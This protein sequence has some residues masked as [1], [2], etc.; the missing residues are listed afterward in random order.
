MKKIIGLGLALFVIFLGVSGRAATVDSEESPPG[1]RLRE[2]F[3]IPAFDPKLKKENSAQLIKG[4]GKFSSQP[5][6][7][8][9]TN[10]RSQLGAIWSKPEF[11]L[12]LSHDLETS[13]WINFGDRGQDAGDGMALVLHNDPR[14]VAA[15]ASDGQSLG[16]WGQDQGD[17]KPNRIA[18]S[19]IRNSWAL[20]FDT[21]SNQDKSYAHAFDLGEPAGQHIAAN[22]PDDTHTYVDRGTNGFFFGLFGNH[23]YGMVHQNPINDIKLSDG[24]WHHLSLKWRAPVGKPRIGQLTY[25]IDDKDPDTGMPTTIARSQ[26]ADV[27]LNKLN[28]TD[29]RVYWGFT[30]ATGANY[31]DAKVIFES[32]PHIMDIKAEMSVRD[33]QT[34]KPIID[35]DKVIDGRKIQYQYKLNYT[36]GTQPWTNIWMNLPLDPHFKLDIGNIKFMGGHT[37]DTIT[38]KDIKAGHL[39]LRLEQPL[40]TQQNVIQISLVGHAENDDVKSYHMPVVNQIFN[41]DNYIAEMI[42]PAYQVM[43]RRALNLSLGNPATD[44]LSL[45]L[46]RQADAEI[47]GTIA[48]RDNA[49][50]AWDSTQFDTVSAIL[51][52]KKLTNQQYKLTWVNPQTGQFKLTVPNQNLKVGQNKLTLTVTDKDGTTTNQVQANLKVAPGHLMIKTAAAT[53]SF[54]PAIVDGR[55]KQHVARRDDWNVVVSDDRG[56]GS[57]WQLQAAATTPKTD[58]GQKLAGDV[59]FNDGKQDQPLTNGNVLIKQHQTTSERDEHDVD[60]QWDTKR[61]IFMNLQANAVPGQYKTVITWT[62]NNTPNGD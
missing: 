31:E 51:D 30:G 14:G 56:K 8:N 46:K 36:N 50:P 23:Y 17:S 39:R 37:Q 2:V 53:S 28:A 54:K 48:Y 35:G 10:N 49:Q 4:N 20:E 62:L 16:V 9:V 13:M 45:D 42:T 22:Y 40:S 34:N 38:A 26:T 57:Q 24:K 52:G 25:T 11:R 19:A 41:G 27:D 29:N 33:L 3:K 59:V 15:I 47:T 60:Q 12:D 58:T 6:V 5:D 55:A 32:V 43:P 44:N 7:I 61:G 1:L 18:T 21:Y